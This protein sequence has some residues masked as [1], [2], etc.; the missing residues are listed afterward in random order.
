LVTTIQLSEENP[1]QAIPAGRPVAVR[2]G[3]KGQLR[4]SNC[5]LDGIS[6]ENPGGKRP[7][8]KQASSSS[9]IPLSLTMKLGC[10]KCARKISLADRYVLALAKEIW[11]SGVFAHHERDVSAE[12]K[13]NPPSVAVL[14]LEDLIARFGLAA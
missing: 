8:R 4:W 5:L 1:E 11:G 12:L 3:E 13:E 6:P 9:T 2:N 10:K 7:S 14:F